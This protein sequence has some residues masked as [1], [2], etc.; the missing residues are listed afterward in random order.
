MCQKKLFSFENGKKLKTIVVGKITILL[1]NSD[2]EVF[3]VVEG[4]LVKP[5]IMCFS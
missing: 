5:L 2:G 3:L 1:K 4:V